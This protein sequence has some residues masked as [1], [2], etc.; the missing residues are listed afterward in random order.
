MS[1]EL[2][3][4]SK[5]FTGLNSVKE[6]LQLQ[7]AQDNKPWTIIRDPSFNPVRIYPSLRKELTNFVLLGD[8]FVGIRSLFT[9]RV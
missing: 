5:N 3:A 9:K 4:A 8:F 1:F 2:S 6:K 7:I